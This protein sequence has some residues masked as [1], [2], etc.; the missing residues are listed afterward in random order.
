MSRFSGAKGSTKLYSVLILFFLL[1]SI[2]LAETE[3]IT[4]DFDFKVDNMT[5]SV[6]TDQG[7]YTLSCGTTSVIKVPISVHHEDNCQTNLVCNVSEIK[8][9]L[10][11]ISSNCGREL[12][13]NISRVISQEVSEKMASQQDWLKNT[14]MPSQDKIDECDNKVLS[15]QVNL[16]SARNKI[17]ILEDKL[18]LTDNIINNEIEDKNTYMYISISCLVVMMLFLFIRKGLPLIRNYESR[19]WKK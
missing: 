16:D 19:F 18:N 12:E 4:T 9:N 17:D 8:E 11:L 15:L 7:N 14:F 3:T 10:D 2:S 6:E 1:V 13:Q 5:A